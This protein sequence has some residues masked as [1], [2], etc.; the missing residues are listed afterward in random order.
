M[1]LSPY[2]KKEQQSVSVSAQQ[3]SDF[4]KEVAQDFNP[5]HDVAAKRFCVPGDLLF[6][7][8]LGQYGLSQKMRFQFEGMV[9]D[10]VSLV[11]PPLVGERFA[12]CDHKDK[13]Y[14]SVERSGDS[15]LC[16]VQTESFIRSY[17]AF[18]GLNFTHVL[19]PLMREQG[20]MINPARPL[21][22]YESMAF[23]LVTLDFNHIELSLVE[24]TLVIDGK[25]GDVTLKFE[26]RCGDKLVGTGVKTLVLSGLRAIE[27]QDMDAMVARYEAR[28][29]DYQGA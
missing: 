9:G 24:Q 28:R 16:D 14:L 29:I 25:R 2:F 11:F 3:A 12:I 21:V 18:S 15:T 23:D 22:I 4:A 8:V 10:G 27:E 17:V 6:A 20:V 13:Q 19:V 5:I 7:L 26:L 1:F